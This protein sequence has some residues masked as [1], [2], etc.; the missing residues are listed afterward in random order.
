MSESYREPTRAIFVESDLHKFVGSPVRDTT[1][2]CLSPSLLD[3]YHGVTL[4]I[5]FHRR[6]K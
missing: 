5:S 6:T 2:V 4:G 3:T 1:C